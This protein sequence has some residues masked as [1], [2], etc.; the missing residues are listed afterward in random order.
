MSIFNEITTNLL[1]IIYIVVDRT[2]CMVDKIAYEKRGNV[3]VRK[4]NTQIERT[5]RGLIFIPAYIAIISIIL[6]FVVPICI[7]QF[8][9]RIIGNR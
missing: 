5:L 3:L 6:M 7:C 4:G 1:N 8:L 2:I 9:D